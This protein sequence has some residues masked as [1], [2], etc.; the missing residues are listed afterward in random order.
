[1]PSRVQNA[2]QKKLVMTKTADDI[3]TV[4]GKIISVGEVLGY[5][6][7]IEDMA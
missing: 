4:K 7:D 6:L 2:E 3:I 1:M 5:S